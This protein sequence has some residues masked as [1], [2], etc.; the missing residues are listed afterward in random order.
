MLVI[1]HLHWALCSKYSVDE[2]MEEQK[3]LHVYPLYITT[4]P[5]YGQFVICCFQLVVLDNGHWVRP[6][7]KQREAL[8]C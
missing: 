2:S 6:L 4:S 1:G 8:N 5:A 3:A 7:Y